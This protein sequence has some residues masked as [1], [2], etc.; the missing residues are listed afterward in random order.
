MGPT[1]LSIRLYSCTEDK[2]SWYNH[3]DVSLSGPAQLS[4]FDTSPRRRD[5]GEWKR[6]WNNNDTIYFSTSNAMI[7]LTN[8]VDLN[9]NVFCILY[10]H[11]NFNA[12]LECAVKDI[13]RS[14]LLILLRVL[15][16]Y[17]F[18]SFTKKCASAIRTCRLTDC[19][20]IE[21]TNTTLSSR[22]THTTRTH[23]LNIGESQ[24]PST[25]RGLLFLQVRQPAF[26]LPDS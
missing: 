1:W 22:L 14:Y 23:C 8:Q 9:R 11:D 5:P 13:I 24:Q 2:D 10:C 3:S 18:Y 21:H 7:L 4:R 19:P 12:F 20:Q 25:A 6:D 15:F 26:R 17:N 16:F